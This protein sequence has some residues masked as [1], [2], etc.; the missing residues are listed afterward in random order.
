MKK[1]LFLICVIVCL[2]PMVLHGF[3]VGQEADYVVRV[4]VDGA[5]VRL[6]PDFWSEVIAVVS[7]GRV[8]S[9]IALVSGWYQVVLENEE[10]ST[11]SGYIHQMQVEEMSG[12]P[13]P[14]AA[15]VPKK[16]IPVQT[17]VTQKPVMT[18]QRGMSSQGMVAQ[19]LYAGGAIGGGVGFSN[20]WAATLSNGKKIYIYPG[21]GVDIHVVIGYK[22][23][24][25]LK[26]EL[27]AAYQSSGTAVS[28]GSVSFKRYPLGLQLLY[29]F[30]SS[31][32]WKIYLGGGP[33]MF[34]GPSYKEKIDSR[35]FYVDY[36]SSLGATAKIGMSTDGPGQR[37][38]MFIEAAYMGAFGYKWNGASFSPPYVLRELSGHGIYFNFGYVFYLGGK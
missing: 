14:E 2:L 11:V 35:E 9:C 6:Q 37:S 28:N 21:G 10:G 25:Q 32:K 8:L 4:K 38:F 3:T 34:I 26:L 29:A 22:L 19:K 5:N 12:E 13:E 18:P 20:F 16:P 15:P 31:K 17:P 33:V 23:M 27:T 1:N 7:K 24:P 30:Q 36:N